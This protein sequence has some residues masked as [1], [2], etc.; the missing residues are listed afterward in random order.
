MH[1]GSRTLAVV[2][3]TAIGVAALGGVAVATGNEP[4]GD[5]LTRPGSVSVSV[6]ERD[7]PDHAAAEREALASLARI[8]EAAARAAATKS[9]GGG[10]AVQAE[11]EDEDGF[12]V[13]DVL[14]RSEDGTAQEVTV[15]AGDASVLAVEREDD[16]DDQDDE[17]DD[18]EDETD[19]DD[20]A[21]D[22]D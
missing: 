1:L 18:D 17:V 16:Q 7:L 20:D 2:G 19:D 10:E 11:L 6:N 5:D 13:W 12:V 21:A 3:A 8:D 9:L 15:D 4:W 14:V 22:D